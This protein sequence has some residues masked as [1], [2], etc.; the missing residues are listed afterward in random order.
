MKNYEAPKLEVVYFT[1]DRFIANMNFGT[2]KDAAQNGNGGALQ[3][4]PTSESSSDVYMP[5]Y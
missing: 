1:P 5:R 4:D 3:V 2:L